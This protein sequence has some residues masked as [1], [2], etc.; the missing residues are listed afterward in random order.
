MSGNYR[1]DTNIIIALLNQDAGIKQKAAAVTFYLPAIAPGELYHGAYKSAKI[2]D[3]LNRIESFLL[4]TTILNCDRVT[5]QFF[6]RIREQ[7][8]TKGRP[9]PENDIWIAATARQYGLILV[10]QDEHFQHVDGLTLEKW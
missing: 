2:Q 3:N 1:L 8:R 7:L 9:I 6:G 10:T 4:D 5:A